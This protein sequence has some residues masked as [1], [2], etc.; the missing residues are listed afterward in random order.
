MR[1]SRR[2]VARGSEEAQEAEEEEDEEGSDAASVKDEEE[3][4][5]A[6]CAPRSTHLKVVAR[7][8]AKGTPVKAKPEAKPE[9]RGMDT[10]ESKGCKEAAGVHSC[11][12]RRGTVFSLAYVVASCLLWASY[13]F[14]AVCTF[15]SVTASVFAFPC[16]TCFARSACSAHKLGGVW[17]S[18]AAWVSV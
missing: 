12:G 7:M 17:V 8:A 6:R 16:L 10:R 3:P 18:A 13:A 15:D 11:A 4:S 14:Y 1:T 9:A 5:L 2:G